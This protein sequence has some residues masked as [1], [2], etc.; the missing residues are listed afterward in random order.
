VKSGRST[1][2]AVPASARVGFRLRFGIPAS[3]S[4]LKAIQKAF[5]APS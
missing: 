5:P 4:R 1:G 3:R 2:I